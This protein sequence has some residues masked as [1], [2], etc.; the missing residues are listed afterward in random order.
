MQ[1]YKRKFLVLASFVFLFASNAYSYFF[2]NLQS[3]GVFDE[4]KIKKTLVDFPYEKDKFAMPFAMQSP[5]IKMAAAAKKDMGNGYSYFLEKIAGFKSKVSGQDE[6]VLRLRKQLANESIQLSEDDER[7]IKQWNN[8]VR[9]QY[10]SFLRGLH[11]FDYCQAPLTPNRDP[12]AF[13][14]MAD[15]MRMYIVSVL[16][17]EEN[18][19]ESSELFFQFMSEAVDCGS[20]INSSIIASSLYDL[21]S[22]ILEVQSKS[23]KFS[24]AQARQLYALLPPQEFFTVMAN[25]SVLFEFWTGYYVTLKA[26]A[27]QFEKLNKVYRRKYPKDKNPLF[28]QKW[29]MKVGSSCVAQRL[30]SLVSDKA[31]SLTKDCFFIVSPLFRERRDLSWEEINQVNLKD[32]GFFDRAFVDF[33]LESRGN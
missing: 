1:I 11:G 9:Y 23:K 20:D 32:P 27:P 17:S 22:Q 33:I 18:I 13:F 25:N 7:R 26:Y 8:E 3:L 28:S 4:V 24:K 31:S 5:F 10:E 15:H 14:R 12:R 19:L 16:F 2:E 30:S 6:L 29:Q 21:Y